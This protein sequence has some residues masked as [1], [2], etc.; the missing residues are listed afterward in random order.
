M[1][2]GIRSSFALCLAGISSC[3]GGGSALRPCPEPPAEASPASHL[4]AAACHRDRGD[5]ERSL[6]HLRRAAERAPSEAGSW[7]RLA[8]A[9]YDAGL[10]DWAARTYAETLSLDPLDPHA[11]FRLGVIADRR[12]ASDEAARWYRACLDVRPLDPKAHYNLAV[13]LAEGLHDPEGARAHFRAALSDPGALP[14]ED[15][16]RALRWLQGEGR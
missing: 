5:T 12:G 2:G 13:I 4:E 9:Y 14:G 16:A 6:S 10:L 1:R 11:R 7:E 3:A 15:R 8:D